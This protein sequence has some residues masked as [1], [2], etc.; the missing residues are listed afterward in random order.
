MTNGVNTFIVNCISDITANRERCKELVENSVGIITAICPHVG[1]KTAAKIAQEAIET[2]GSVRTIA[3]R[4]G[5]IKEAE[6]NY[7][8]DPFAMTEPGIPGKNLILK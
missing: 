4:E 2:G 7:I 5:V 6:L 1:Y 8:L 3:L